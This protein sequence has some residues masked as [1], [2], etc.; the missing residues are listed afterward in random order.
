MVERDDV[1]LPRDLVGEGEVQATLI[2][3]IVIIMI[4]ITLIIM[5]IIVIFI[6]IMIVIVIIIV[7]MSATY[8]VHHHIDYNDDQIVALHFLLFGIWD[9]IWEF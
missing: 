1:W 9:F 2:I 8:G 6:T 3:M 5:I 4:N 7:T